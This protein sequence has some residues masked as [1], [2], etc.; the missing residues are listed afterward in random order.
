VSVEALPGNAPAPRELM[1]SD[2]RWLSGIE[3]VAHEERASLRSWLLTP[4][5][6]TQ[7]IRAAAGTDFSMSVL[8]EQ[9]TAS[10]HERE[11]DMRCAGVVW[12]F[13]HTSIPA[14]TLS[15]Q[16]W[17]GQIG[18][19]A[20]G[21]ALAAH[22]GCTRADFQ[23]VRLGA[24]HWLVHRALQHA[25]LAPQSLWVRRSVITVTGSAFSLY[26]VFLPAIGERPSSIAAPE[27][28]GTQPP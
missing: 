8:R 3:L 5:L 16:P 19:T 14:P 12:L 18:N 20:L 23:Y 26:E 9:T 13:A 17:L 28:P 6:L 25:S 21:E 22:G 2:T 24:D 4:G 11:I 7:R 10:G 27:F 1:P 15:A